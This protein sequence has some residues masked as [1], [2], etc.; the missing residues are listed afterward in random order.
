[1]KF[2]NNGNSIRMRLG[3]RINCVWKNLKHGEVIDLDNKVGLRY[4]LEK[5][6]S[7][8][9]PKTEFKPKKRKYK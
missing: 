6:V 2:K 8:N 1:M 4:K 3:D 5:V 7:E 9:K